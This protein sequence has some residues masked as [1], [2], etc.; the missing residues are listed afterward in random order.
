MFIIHPSNARNLKTVK[1]ILL[2]GI[3]ALS[4]TSA[5]AQTDA[6][7]ENSDA[8][9]IT[10]TA[11]RR[12]QSINEVP[13]S[14]NS[15]DKKL[16]DQQGIR[17]IDDLARYTPSL[18]F[19]RAASING[20]SSTISI[21]GLD[22]SVGS[23]TTAIYIDETPIQISNVG[24]F[25]GNPY[26]QIFDLDHVEVL[27]GPQGTLFGASA[28]GGAVRFITPGPNYDALHTYARA[29]VSFTEHG[30]PSYET[31]LAMGAPIT[32]NL[33]FRMSGWYQRTGGYIDQVTQG[34]D[35]VIH[36]DINSSN[37]FVYHAV[38]GWEPMDT[39]TI[40]PSFYYQRTHANARDVSWEGYGD[41]GKGD[42]HSGV[43]GSE[44]STDTFF[45]PALK[46]DW[47]VAP[48]VELITNTSYFHRDQNQTLDYS[49]YFSAQR[50][51][52]DAF[53]TYSNKDISNAQDPLTMKQR[54]FAQE[55]RLQ[56]YD[57]ALI[58]WTTGVYFSNT[59]QNFTNFTESGRIPETLDRG[60]PQYEGIYSYVNWT[61]AKEK[62]IAG[63]ASV[64]A[65]PVDGLTLTAAIRYS[66]FDLDFEDISDGSRLANVRTISTASTKE[67]AW[68]PK[69]GVSYKIAPDNMVYATVVKGFRAAGA[70][71][72]IVNDACSGDFATLGLSESPT[73][74][75]SDSLWS[76][77]A[78]T[79]NSL[80][81]GKLNFGASA[82]V[83]KW[84]NIQ[85]SVS[86]P[87]C[88]SSFIY[89]L[90]N[91][92]SKGFEVSL[93]VRPVFGLNL[94]GNAG[95]VHMTYD[96]DVL[97][98][99]G[100]LLKASG[101]RI[102]GPAWTGHLYASYETPIGVGAK[103][104]V[105]GDY[106]FAS[107]QFRP[108]SNPESYSYDGA[109]EPPGARN[110]VSARIGARFGDADVS[111]FVDNLLNS[112]DALVRD[113]DSTSA[114]LF[115]NVTYRPRTIG[116]TLHYAN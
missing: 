26:P 55:A 34:T 61:E 81:G 43:Y 19:N 112:N 23:S 64:D 25:G 96:D 71:S 76:Y 100:V 39:L 72:K 15:Y 27:Y 66:H 91:A 98:G 85:Q 116:L 79:K 21:R 70:Q 54:N 110:F 46:V 11:Q 63:Y 37:A 86:L 14:I 90:G 56:S 108:D 1:T 41:P 3:S 53:G 114:W 5:L 89:N 50:A 111:L 105:R 51:A 30:A 62:Q 13:M 99:S 58:D 12:E 2:A 74:Y 115:Y 102:G 106:T 60:Y 97:G 88:Q 52:G 68:T 40:T 38:V 20:Q 75:Q 92:T 93:D 82:Y 9:V 28:E 107:H 36:K 6:A 69:F 87:N 59:K 83:M 16:M 45:L 80:G 78:G 84:K 103:A 29:Q 8:G 22:S 31:G 73:S 67:G 65:K 42:Y 10:V 94:G 17:G 47:K 49:T 33:A 104:Y 113:H 48:N 35:D 44:P 109:L 77:E 7:A 95:Y 57:N 24:Y 32:D 18:T 101:D 4:S